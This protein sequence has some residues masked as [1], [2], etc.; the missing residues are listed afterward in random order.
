MARNSKEQEV[1]TTDLEMEAN[2]ADPRVYE[3]GFHLDGELS[4]EDAKKAYQAIKDLIAANGSII[5][6]GEAEKIQLAY[7]ISRMEPTGRRDWNT[8]Y[9]GWVVYEAQGEGHEAVV[10]GAGAN[11]SIIRFLDLRTTREA[12]QHAAEMH[13]FYRKLPEMA[14][15]EEEAADA[16]LDA[17]LKEAGVTA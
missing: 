8:A 1:E 2:H 10:H 16:E 6:E 14:A 12:A 11:S 3:L 13:E 9:F 15:P 7:T 17:A 4:Q 5:N